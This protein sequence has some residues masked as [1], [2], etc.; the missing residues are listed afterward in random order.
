MR[1]PRSIRT[2]FENSLCSKRRS[3]VSA[4]FGKR[5]IPL[6]LFGIFTSFSVP[7]HWIWSKGANG[8]SSNTFGKRFRRIPKLFQ[9]PNRRIYAKAYAQ[10]G[11]M[12]AAFEMFKTF[13]TQDAADYRQFAA[14]KLPMPVLTIEGDKAMGGA[15][16][17]QAKIVASNVT[18]IILKDTG[19][20]SNGQKN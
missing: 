4:T 1:T 15:L 17:I 9:K 2:T 12:R 5:S 8:Y 20:W 13:D 16:E 14:T 6:L 7:L 19:S 3:Q 11:A 18:S 10:E